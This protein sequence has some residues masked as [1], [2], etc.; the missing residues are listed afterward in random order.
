VADLCLKESKNDS[1]SNNKIIHYNN[2]RPDSKT[3]DRKPLSHINLNK[4]YN[5]NKDTKDTKDTKD[6]KKSFMRDEEPQITWASA[7]E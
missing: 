2:S 5:S 3:S 4:K 7:K 6:N 1:N